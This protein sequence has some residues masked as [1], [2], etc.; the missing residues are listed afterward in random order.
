[1]F[2]G[3]NIPLPSRGSGIDT[4]PRESLVLSFPSCSTS[5][6][7]D[8][9][10]SKGVH[11]LFKSIRKL[12]DIT[13]EHLE[14]LNVSLEYDVPLEGFI[15]TYPPQSS[16]SECSTPVS[17]IPN[18]NGEG[19]KNQTFAER[20]KELL[21]TN[22]HAFETLQRIRRDKL[23]HFYKFYQSLELVS[24]YYNQKDGAF[25]GMPERFREDL[26]KNFIEPI[27]WGYNSRLM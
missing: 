15:P 13:P 26:V 27:C 3:W 9:T 11:Q 1:M 2:G 14:S 8:P 19:T 20:K 5:S 12:P 10:F 7:H 22:E 23:G 18:E 24:T 6:P 21:I 16:T 4:T 17:Y 25:A